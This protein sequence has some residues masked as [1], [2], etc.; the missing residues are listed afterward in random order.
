MQGADQG[1]ARLGLCGEGAG[2][3]SGGEAG[4]GQG[5][6]EG[7]P[8]ADEAG[9]DEGDPLCSGDGGQ[10]RGRFRDVGGRVDVESQRPQIVLE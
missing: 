2:H 1:G 4:V 6:P 3:G 8:V 9:V 5:E 7:V 10:Q